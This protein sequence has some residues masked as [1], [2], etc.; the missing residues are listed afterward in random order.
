MPVS[1]SYPMSNTRTSYVSFHP[2]YHSLLL[3]S[4]ING[5]FVDFMRNLGLCIVIQRWK[6]HPNRLCMQIELA[7]LVT[8]VILESVPWNPDIQ[9]N[10]LSHLLMAYYP[11]MD[12]FSCPR[13]GVLPLNDGPPLAFFWRVIMHPSSFLPKSEV[14]DPHDLRL[15]LKV[16]SVPRFH[17]KQAV[18][19]AYCFCALPLSKFWHCFLLYFWPFP[20]IM[21]FFPSLLSD[22]LFR[23]SDGFSAS[24]RSYC[25]SISSLAVWIPYYL[26]V[27]EDPGA[28]L[29]VC[30]F[31]VLP[32]ITSED[33]L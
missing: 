22:C 23:S 17:A 25:A 11:S 12:K 31:S 16:S 6:W 21:V 1:S 19:N 24:C 15:S 4:G 27:L 26:A 32:P 30:R 5:M 14:A 2:V 8:P 10:L 3:L 7:I 28:L 18:I 9:P 20:S 13:I 33:I 29:H